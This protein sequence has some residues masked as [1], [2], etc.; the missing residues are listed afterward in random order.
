M[1]I[2][3]DME[4]DMA[5]MADQCMAAMAAQ[6]MA[7]AMVDQCTVVASMARICKVVME[8]VIERE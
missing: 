1:V 2:M 4:M 3:E 6:C 8:E 5:A 7:V